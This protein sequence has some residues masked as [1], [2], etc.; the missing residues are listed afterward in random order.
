MENFK[1]K[2]SRK[3]MKNRGKN[4]FVDR[5]ISPFTFYKKDNKWQQ[6]RS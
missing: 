2:K 3:K 4:P 5:G 6:K 1:G